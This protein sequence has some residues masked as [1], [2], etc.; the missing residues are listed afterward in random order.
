M[1]GGSARAGSAGRRPA[2][3]RRRCRPR[4]APSN[5]VGA[6]PADQ[7]IAAP[8]ASAP[9]GHPVTQRS[10]F[11]YNF[12]RPANVVRKLRASLRRTPER[13]PPA[14]PSPARFGPR[15]LGQPAPS[16]T[17]C[18]VSDG[19]RRADSARVVACCPHRLG[20][21]DHNCEL[22]PLLLRACPHRLLAVGTR[23]QRITRPGHVATHSAAEGLAQSAAPD[24]FR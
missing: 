15:R 5:A 19:P 23:A 22:R 7:L 1:S 18:A 9:D 6:P 3:D 8:R 11:P 2:C 16:R 14:R 20:R 10:E 24:G 4:S 21:L 12:R 13:A 17:V